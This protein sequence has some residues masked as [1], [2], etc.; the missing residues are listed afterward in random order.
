L[1][2]SLIDINEFTETN[3]RDDNLKTITQALLGNE[4]LT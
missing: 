4:E 3:K 2:E 1:G